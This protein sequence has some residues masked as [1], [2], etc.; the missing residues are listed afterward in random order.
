M[1]SHCI[2][3]IELEVLYYLILN[4][5]ATWIH[6]LGPIREGVR[7]HNL[8]NV[9]MYLSKWYQLIDMEFE[10][11]THNMKF[12]KF[13]YL[14]TFNFQTWRLNFVYQDQMKIKYEI[15]GRLNCLLR[16]YISGYYLRICNW[17]FNAANPIDDLIVMYLFFTK[18]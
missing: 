1:T 15:F 7:R 10:S 12:M 13:D 3:Y 2:L 16:K 14:V 9:K 5:R 6:V 17:K 4:C 11:K 8:L 18:L